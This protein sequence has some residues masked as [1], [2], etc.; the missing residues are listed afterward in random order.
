MSD[1]RFVFEIVRVG[2]EPLAKAE[3]ARAF[4]HLRLAFSRPGLLTFKDP[5]GSLD[6]SFGEGLVFPRVS[7]RSLGSADDAAGIAAL[8]PEGTRALHVFPRTPVS[9]PAAAAALE[10][11][12]ARLDAAVRAAASERLGPPAPLATGDL[13]CDVAFAP[14]ERHF[15]GAHRHAPG[16]WATPGG[17]AVTPERPAAPSRAYRKL[18][19]A[20]AWSGLSMHPGE[21]A[22]ELGSAPGGM[23]LAL[24]ERGVRVVAVDSAAM[25]PE[26]LAHVGPGGARVEH[27]VVAAGGVRPEQLP[28]F[29]DWIVCDLNLAPPVALRYVAR[30]VRARPP[31]RGVLVTLKLNDAAMV[32][33][34]P[35][36]LERVR[37]MGLSDVRATQLPANRSEVTVL[38]L[39][40]PSRR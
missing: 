21:V 36:H 19:E 23:T 37:G 16:R 15:V 24:L 30:V 40:R 7:G 9:E 31:R 4:P 28:P 13:V 20:L 34:I 3:I 35:E 26:V 8:V 27:L 2:A 11:E 32:A 10:A 12:R 33:Q 38:A 6:E 1:P 39:A 29:L 17:L 22:L 25:S 5:G 18:D 14:G